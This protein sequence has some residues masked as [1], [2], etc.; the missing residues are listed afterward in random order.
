MLL[1]AGRAS[2]NR[3]RPYRQRDEVSMDAQ[4]AQSKFQQADDLFKQGRHQ[5]AF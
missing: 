5:E 1:S 3:E 2:T 4:L